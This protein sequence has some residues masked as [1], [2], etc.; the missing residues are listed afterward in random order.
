[1]RSSAEHVIARV[2][3]VLR[4]HGWAGVFQR[5][6]DGISWDGQALELSGLTSRA[7]SSASLV[8][9]PSVFALSG[10]IFRVGV[11]DPSVV[12]FPARGIGLL[13]S[14][15][16]DADADP[17]GL[18]ALLGPNR[19]RVLLVLQ[20]P[21]TVSRLRDLLGLSLGSLSRHLSILTATGL[22]TSRRVGRTV[23]YE[24]SDLG[25]ALIAAQDLTGSGTV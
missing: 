24:V 8:L 13:F 2:T 15:E 6:G 4:T 20:H 21:T 19:A 14:L 25:H 12:F 1:M 16:A 9:A 22:T 11:T 7:P 5:I 3:D 23:E 18:S 17:V 10:P